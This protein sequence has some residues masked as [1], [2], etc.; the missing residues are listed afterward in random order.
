MHRQAKLEDG[1]FA[2]QLGFICT[3]PIIKALQHCTDK[4]TGRV[5]PP[6]G[7]SDVAVV[8]LGAGK[9]YLGGT[10]VG[11]CGVRRLV[12]TDVRSGFKLKV[13]VRGAGCEV[14]CLRRDTSSYCSCAN[15][16]CMAK[17]CAGTLGAGSLR[18]CVGLWGRGGI[19]RGVGA[20]LCVRGQEVG[21]SPLPFAA[22]PVCGASSLHVW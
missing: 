3:T 11:C 7:G 14:R 13:W 8:E 2:V 9:G 19:R 10:L 5:A 12:V 20:R 17:V 1:P 18:Q 21:V 6:Q 15:T 4:P 16:P 22:V